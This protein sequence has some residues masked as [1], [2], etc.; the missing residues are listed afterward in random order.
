VSVETPVKTVDRLVRIL[1]SFSP[2][3]SAWSLAD[4]SAHLELP[5]S[6]LH[7]FLT[8]L[9]AH[10]ILRRDPQDRQWRFGYRPFIWGSLAAE[11]TDLRRLARPTMRDLVTAT[12]ETAI[13]TVY[14][15]RDVIC[16]ERVETTRPVRLTLDVGARRSPHAGANSKALMAYL[17]HSEIQAIIHERGLPRLC[18]NTI[19]DPDALLVELARI[20]ERGYAESREET[21]FG[22]WGV[23]TPIHD[24]SGVLVAAIGIAGPLSRLTNDRQVRDVALSRQAAQ[25]ISTLLSAG[26]GL[27]AESAPEPTAPQ[28]R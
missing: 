14:R 12:G 21:D 25:R 5:K 7:R 2:E 23:A 26:M 4:L 24:V 27:P 15:E 18:T 28:R 20:R 9:E 22:A 1:D 16:I 11:S 3:R 6:T 8:S 10:G 19:T 13:L 17:P